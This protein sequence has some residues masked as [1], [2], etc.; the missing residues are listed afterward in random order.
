ML[1]AIDVGNTETKLGVFESASGA[2]LYMWRVTTEARR[3]ADEYGVF[4]TQLFV[5]QKIQTRDVT[6]VV[7]SSVVPKLDQTIGDACRRFVGAKTEFLKS[8]QQSLMP[9]AT[10]RPSEVG[11]DLVAM[12]LGARK[13]YGAPLIVISFGTATAFVAIS[14]DGAFLGTAIA[15]G[16]AISVDALVGRAAKLP[17]I[18]LEAP[19]SAI[20]RDTIASLQSGIVY[21]FVGQ[22]EAIVQRMSSEMN[23]SPKVIATG[24]LAEV[25][26]K[27]TECIHEVNANL[28]LLGLQLFHNSTNDK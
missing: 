8:H 13:L 12:S 4:L 24:G 18:A 22:T 27:H 21:G 26:A 11:A 15:P 1:L 10:E 23:A 14:S 16:I 6:A 20:G 25:V 7:I 28:S 19:G 9:I 2:L 3:T 17:Q 5:T